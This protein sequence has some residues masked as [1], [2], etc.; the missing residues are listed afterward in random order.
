MT[1]DEIQQLLPSIFQRG[2]LPRTPMYG[3]LEV[4]EALHRPA[5][6]TLRHLE[7]I[8]DPRRTPD[9]FVPYLATWVDLARIFPVTTD[10]SCL[11]DLVAIAAE[12]A[13]RRGTAGGLVLFLETAT[14][15]RGFAVDEHVT[16]A[17]G[18][19]RPFHVRVRA[20]HGTL[21]HRA[22]IERII[23]SEKPV[24]VTYDLEFQSSDS[25]PALSQ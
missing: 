1:P 20:P 6:D 4:M 14:A 13:R 12:L 18:T 10:L 24:H 25:P 7:V 5:E 3:L 8:F 17:D 19:P 9:R 15:T 23:D 2:L 16:T 22:L 11:R 21:A